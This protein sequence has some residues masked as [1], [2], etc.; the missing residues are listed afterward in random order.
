MKRTRAIEDIKH[1]DPPQIKFPGKGDDH[2][3]NP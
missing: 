1:H 2:N 3:S